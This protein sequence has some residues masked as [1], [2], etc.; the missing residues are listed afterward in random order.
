M[1]I[2]A[3]GDRDMSRI[4]LEF[5]GHLAAVACESAFCSAANKLSYNSTPAL[6]GRARMSMSGKKVCAVMIS[7][8]G[9]E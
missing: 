3:R 4:K 5:D 1:L 9:G 7:E 6:Y 2:T 8:I